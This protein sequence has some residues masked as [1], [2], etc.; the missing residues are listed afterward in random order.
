MT[1]RTSFRPYFTNA[2]RYGL[3]LALSLWLLPRLYRTLPLTELLQDLPLVRLPWLGAALGANVLNHTLRAFRWRLLLRAAGYPVAIG[4]LFIAEMGGFFANLLFPRL[5]EVVRCLLLQRMLA[6]PFSVAFGTVLSERLLDITSF[7]L[8]AI[9][10]LLLEDSGLQQALLPWL[11]QRLAAFLAPSSLVLWAVVLLVV[12]ALLASPPLRK[13]LRLG[14][15]FHPLGRGIRS[16]LLLNNQVQLWGLTS[17]IWS[18]YFLV[19]YWGFKGVPATAHLGGAAGLAVFVVSNL[20]MAAPVQGGGMGAYHVLVGRTLENFGIAATP[21][22]LYATITHGLQLLT[23]LV[24][25]GICALVGSMWPKE[26]K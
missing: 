14:R 7:G 13:K 16:L 22:L 26:H 8:V 18:A 19:G 10:T 4:Y 17:A 2:L 12:L 20:S 15:V 11:Q 3:P 9:G 24:L 6:V 23:G 25:G 5:G 1:T 21:A